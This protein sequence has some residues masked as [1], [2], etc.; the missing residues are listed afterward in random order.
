MNV[1]PRTIFCHDNLDIL[2]G[3]DDA[4]VD[5]IYLDPPFNKN[6]IFT[7]PT[8]TTASG[9]SFKDIW[10]QEDIKEEWVEQIKGEDELRTYLES[11]REFTPH[12]S[13]YCYLVY[14]A[15]RLLEMKRVL[16][17][18][19]SLYYHCDHTMSAYIKV[20]LD[21]VFGLTE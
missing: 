1:K 10:K 9:A 3:M 2:R 7:A 17:G 13:N 12:I 16:K 8:G 18:G 15:I 5:L 6:E 21:M 19:G 4:C 11:V 14:M 20:L